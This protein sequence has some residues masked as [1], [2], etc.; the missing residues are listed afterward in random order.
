MHFQMRKKCGKKTVDAQKL[1]KIPHTEKC[2]TR[3]GSALKTHKKNYEKN[4]CYTLS[5]ICLKKKKQT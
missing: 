2:K 4:N 1:A 5:N 3:C